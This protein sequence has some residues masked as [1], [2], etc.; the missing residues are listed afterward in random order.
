MKGGM[1][2]ND[3]LHLIEFRKEVG[4]KDIILEQCEEWDSRLKDYNIILS[5]RKKAEIIDYIDQS[6]VH[7]KH[8]IEILQKQP[9]IALRKI[10]NLENG[11]SFT[12]S[13]LERYGIEN[14]IRQQEDTI[15][16][17]ERLD[18]TETEPIIQKEERKETVL[19]EIS[20]RERLP[21]DYMEVEP[22]KIQICG[23]YNGKLSDLM[24]GLSNEIGQVVIPFEITDIFEQI[25]TLKRYDVRIFNGK[26]YALSKKIRD[27]MVLKIK[28]EAIERLKTGIPYNLSL[29]TNFCYQDIS[30]KTLLLTV[31]EW[32][33][34]CN[35]F[36]NYDAG[37]F[38]LDGDLK[39][40]IG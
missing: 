28:E 6:E 32:T 17:K 36:R 13:F 34:L 39:L 31:S 38:L 25:L 19:E 10:F 5:E 29:W 9:E 20:E 15:E 24:D 12:T 33:M 18:G 16:Y 27:D 35:M 23:D 37:V 4:K 26:K 3:L 1:K 11:T 40:R 21:I 14:V 8:L 30:Y 22:V 7:S 2:L